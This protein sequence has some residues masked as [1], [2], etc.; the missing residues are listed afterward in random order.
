MSRRNAFRELGVTPEKLEELYVHCN[1]SDSEIAGLYGVSDAA[2]SYFRKRWGI[3]TKSPLERLQFGKKSLGWEGITPV[4]LAT[5]YSS[6]GDRGIAALYN[7]SPPTVRNK[8]KLFGI[9]SISKSE[10]ATSCWALTDVQRE[11]LIGSLLGDGHLLEKGSFKVAHY[12]EQLGYLRSLHQELRPISKPIYYEEK[13]M[14]NGRLAL[15]FGFLTE[16]HEWLRSLYATFYPEG[17]KVFPPSVLSVLTPRSLAYWYFDDGHLD[18]LPSIALGS[19]KS[20]SE[21]QAQEISDVVGK[22]FSLSLYPKLYAGVWILKFRA[23]T[24]DSFFKLIRG[25]VSE[26][27]VY[28]LPP[29]H[30]PQGVPLLFPTRTKDP[31]LLPRHLVSKARGWSNESDSVKQQTVDE[32]TDFWRSVGFPYHTPRPE[33]L[34]VLLNLEQSQVIQDGH[35]KSRQV[36]QS[37]C[38]GICKGIWSGRSFGGAS[39]EEVFRDPSRLRK[40]IEF[41][42]QTG[43]LPNASRLRGALRFKGHT[44][45]YNFR[46]SAAKVLVDRFCPFEGTVLDPCG[47]YGGRLLGSLLSKAQPTY[48]AYEPSTQAFEGLRRLHGW[49]CSYLPEKASKVFLH[50]EPAEQATFVSGVDVVLT[51]PPYWKREVYSEEETQSS[52]RY[53]TYK[54]WLREFWEKVLGSSLEA[55]KPGGWLVLNVDDFSVSGRRYPL[56]SDTLRIAAALGLSNPEKYVY[57]LPGKSGAESVLC[58]AKKGASLEVQHP[59]GVS[60]LPRCVSCGRVFPEE[61]LQGKVCEK[62][63]LPKGTPTVCEGC[64][65]EFLATR[66]DQRFHD[67][68]CYARYRRRK[69]RAECPSTGVRTFVC[70]VC[71]S[72]WATSKP[73]RFTTC[74]ECAAEKEVAGRRKVCAYRYCGESFVDTSS[75]NS[76]C[77]CSPEHRR[78]EKLLRLGIAKDES[79]FKTPA[80]P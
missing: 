75:R 67:K 31:V 6:M 60:S 22:R 51:S 65:V 57:D 1:K 7:V 35:I 13:E 50:H 10:R 74:P 15:A 53:T 44:G 70:K 48:V 52:V 20:I 34:G 3:R 38:Q 18:G 55:L 27:M 37:V 56:V 2:V 59:A 8:R 47:G 66:A 62:C 29:K 63:S 79:Y 28:K 46:P 69:K 54:E 30:R 41:C 24:A 73:G 23:I 16:P 45:V 26:D 40:A 4:E 80:R 68:A 64:G 42:L 9:T 11:V 36:G 43:T 14:D 12:Q 33:E 58:W 76:M 5:L 49:V 77:Y 78:R 19:D 32:F 17:E 21:R 71:G 25:F 39:P 61:Q 72:S